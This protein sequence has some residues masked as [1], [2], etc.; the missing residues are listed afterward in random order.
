MQKRTFLI[1]SVMLLAGSAIAQPDNRSA[2]KKYQ[3]ASSFGVYIC[4]LTFQYYQA[5]G[6]ISEDPEKRKS[7]DYI[8]CIA[9]NKTEIRSAFDQAI[10]T[11]RKPAAKA[12]LK[13]HLV[14]SLSALQGIAPLSGELTISYKARQ[15]ANQARMEEQWTRFEIEQ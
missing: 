8:G 1:V 3:N 2:V 10:A 5:L 14:H 6:G 13:E 9:E 12:A 4:G 11:V 7:S 15:G